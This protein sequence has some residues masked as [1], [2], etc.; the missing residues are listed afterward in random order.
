MSERARKLALAAVF[1]ASATAVSRVVGLAREVVVAGAYGAGV[2]YS[3]FVS[4]S[5]VPT[6][7]RQLF[8]DAAISAAFVPVL[9]GLLAAGEQGRAR[10][11]TG[12]LLGFMLTVVGAAVLVL[13]AAAE[14]IVEALYP[15]L[16]TTPEAVAAAAEYL[17]IV[18][19][20]ILVLALA[21]VVTGVLFARERFVMPAVV[22]IVWNV[23]IIGFVTAWH[24]S[25]GVPA[26]AWGILAGTVVEL[27]LLIWAMRAVG[28]PVSVNLRFGDDQFR[29]V[30]ALMVPVSITLGILNFNAL[31]NMYFAQYVSDQ[32]AAE[33]IYAFRLY[34]LPQG[35]FAVTIGTVLFPSL[36]RFAA[37]HDTARFRETL[38]LAVRQTVF[39]SL[40]FVVWFAVLAVPMVR[41]VFERGA[42]SAGDTSA[43]APV[44]AAFAVGLTF[45]NVN[46]MFNR[47]F[48][49]M[50]RVWLPLYV[51]LACLALNAVL[52]WVLLHPFGAAGIALSTSLVSIFNCAAL[53]YLLRDRIGAAEGRRMALAAGKALVCAA[54]VATVAY[55][56]WRALEGF[57][58]GG[59]GA[60]LAALLVAVAASGATYIGAARLLHLEELGLAWRLLRRRTG[61]TTQDE[62]AEQAEEPE[63]DAE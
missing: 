2:D 24:S 34:T 23:V 62:P 58:E 41:V 32:A 53:G 50:Q 37:Q 11:V 59:F 20:T 49:S 21:G 13:I 12:A 52:A 33:I 18:A 55:V 44:L 3:T 16:T 48:Q 63:Q 54:A 17:R 28:E 7:I 61:R 27:V 5:A 30:L 57:A 6:T 10:R 9:V 36:S 45:A 14:P 43:V 38:S 25:W 47:S 60:A 8:A 26:L 46:T 39:V 56:V 31:V 1:V 15:E 35:I 40:P 51:G 19:P 29:R 4:V 22:S 42:F